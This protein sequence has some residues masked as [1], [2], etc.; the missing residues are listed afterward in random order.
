MQPKLIAMLTYMDCTV[1]DAEDVFDSAQTAPVQDW[2]LKDIGLDL[3]QMKNLVQSMKKASKT[4]YLE[5]VSLSEE[6]GLAGAQIATELG[7]DVVMGTVFFTSIRDYLKERHIAYYPFVGPVHGH[8]TVL[9]GSVSEIIEQARNLEAQGVDGLDLLSYRY[10][11]EGNV[12]ELLK[13]VVRAT[14]IPI[15]SAGSIDSFNRISV[16]RDAGAWG[17]TIG[18]AFFEKRFVKDGTF[19]DNVNSVCEWLARQGLD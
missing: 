7:I 4:T 13:Q 2:G 3:R 18:S 14:R 6:E 11:Y 1:A 19:V 17:F 5:V 10:K 12:A 9:D 15:V 8:P 16:V